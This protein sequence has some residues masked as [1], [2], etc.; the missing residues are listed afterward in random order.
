MTTVTCPTASASRGTISTS[1]RTYSDYC[2]GASV[3]SA[4]VKAPLCFSLRVGLDV[5]VMLARAST[6]ARFLAFTACEYRIVQAPL[7]DVMRELR[8]LFPHCSSKSTPCE[9]IFHACFDISS[10]GRAE[11]GSNWAA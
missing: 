3:R 5:V 2:C 8:T 1:T 4:S 11:R 7:A 10:T 6:M 9:R